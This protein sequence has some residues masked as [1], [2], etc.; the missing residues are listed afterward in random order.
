MVIKN[1]HGNSAV[2]KWRMDGVEYYEPIVPNGFMVWIQ[3]NP[4]LSKYVRLRPK[5][6]L[7]LGILH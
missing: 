5:A 4:H 7:Q 3:D 2:L 6:W 1:R